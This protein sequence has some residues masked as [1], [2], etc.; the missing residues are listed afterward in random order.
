MTAKDTEISDRKAD[1]IQINLE[2]DVQSGIT[3][4][5]EHYRFQHCAVPNL[6][7]DE[8]SLASR[9]LGLPIA[10]PLLISSMTGGTPEAAIINHH[11][12][13]AAEQTKIPMGVGSQRAALEDTDQ[14][15]S[16][17]V[18]KFAPN[19]PLLANIGAIQ[20]NN[21]Y[22]ID[23]CRR[24][25]EMIQANALILHLNPLQEA[26]QPEGNVHWKGLLPKIEYII[27]HIGV[28]V[29]I[30]EVGWGISGK[31][32]AIFSNMG[33]T[34]ID[35]AGAGGT[36]WSQVEMHRTKETGARTIA[37]AFRSWGIPTAESIQL[38][39]Q[40]APD[41][42]LIA[43]G[44]IKDGHEVAKCIALGASLVGV[45][46]RILRAASTS[47][48]NT[49]DTLQ[50][51]RRELMITMFAADIGSIAELQNSAKLV[52]V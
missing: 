33:V 7:L 12:A 43:S 23:E 5:L 9:F 25:V 31:L 8:I 41:T 50:Q 32:A 37:S 14:A 46:G 21:G 16:F 36:S 34:A 29:I 20:L 49:I 24:A 6:N 38:V 3:T 30:K 45:A 2:Q 22:G 4:G 10:L 19:I 52:H 1:H 28:P 39:R 26:L 11:L 47:T 13:I 40:A 51:I 15:A 35:V 42:T 27:K 44:G 17:Q 48:E 18:R